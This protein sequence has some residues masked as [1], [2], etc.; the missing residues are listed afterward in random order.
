MG[1]RCRC[2]SRGC[3][4]TEVSAPRLLGVLREDQDGNELTPQPGLAQLDALLDANAYAQ[5]IGV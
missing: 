3:L 1:S 2:G 4:E 5:A